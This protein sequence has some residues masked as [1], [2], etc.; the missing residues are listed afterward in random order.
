MRLKGLAQF[1]RRDISILECGP[2]GADLVQVFRCPFT[3]GSYGERRY[4]L[5]WRHSSEA[6]RAERIPVRCPGSRA[7]NP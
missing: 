2:D 5:R 1:F 4:L 6:E 7:A 3:N